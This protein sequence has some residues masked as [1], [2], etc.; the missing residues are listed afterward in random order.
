[1]LKADPRTVGACEAHGGRDA[2]M[3]PRRLWTAPRPMPDSATAGCC[4]VRPVAATIQALDCRPSAGATLAK[5]SLFDL[6]E[7][8]RTLGIGNAFVCRNLGD[9]SLFEGRG[10][11]A[12]PAD[13]TNH[14]DCE[15]TRDE[16]PTQTRD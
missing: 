15:F 4:K 2:G 13:A 7:G 1:M 5:L 3:A 8:L 12:S 16:I 14:R 9:G 11:A 10:V 6:G